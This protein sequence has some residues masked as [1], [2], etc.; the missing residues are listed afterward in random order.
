MVTDN[1]HFRC[2]MNEMN[3]KIL[4]YSDWLTDKINYS[5]LRTLFV[6]NQQ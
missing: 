5:N 4:Y 6:C 2:V 3:V 1:L